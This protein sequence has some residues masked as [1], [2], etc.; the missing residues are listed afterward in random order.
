MVW[1]VILCS[2]SRRSGESDGAARGGQAARDG[3]EKEGGAEGG[4]RPGGRPSR[5]GRGGQPPSGRGRSLDWES[6]G[7]RIRS[8]CVTLWKERQT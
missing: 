5:A 4:G 2:R 1:S 7:R 3:R 6:T 8:E